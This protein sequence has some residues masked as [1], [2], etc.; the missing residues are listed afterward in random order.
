MSRLQILIDRLNTLT[1]A[2]TE[3]SEYRGGLVILL[4]EIDYSG[5]NRAYIDSYIDEYYDSEGQ[6]WVWQKYDWYEASKR[7]FKGI[8]V[9]NE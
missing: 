2:V 6:T 7:R 4:D 8:T 5:A 9:L 3:C 1:P